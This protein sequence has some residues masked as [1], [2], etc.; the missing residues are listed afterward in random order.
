MMSIYSDKFR[1]PESSTKEQTDYNINISS[2]ST[3]HSSNKSKSSKGWEV[4]KKAI[5]TPIGTK[6]VP[7]NRRRRSRRNLHERDVQEDSRG[8]IFYSDSG[9]HGSREKFDRQIE[10]RHNLEMFLEEEFVQFNGFEGEQHQQRFQETHAQVHP[11]H[12]QHHQL[13]Q[14]HQYHQYHHQYAPQRLNE[15]R[16]EN[17]K[18]VNGESKY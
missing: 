9:P 12:E 2:S 14:L 18:L 13:H 8:K 4:I 16:E 5:F 6:D 15:R 3:S 7:K 11:S 10:D 17:L 1:S